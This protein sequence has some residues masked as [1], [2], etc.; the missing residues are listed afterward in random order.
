MD[1]TCPAEL[2]PPLGGAVSQHGWLKT[3]R[4]TH[5]HKLSS[6][7]HNFLI[8]LFCTLL[9]VFLT[10]M[11]EP[12]PALLREMTSSHVCVITRQYWE[13][14]IQISWMIWLNVWSLYSNRNIIKDSSPVFLLFPTEITEI[15]LLIIY[16]PSFVCLPPSF[17][18]PP[19]PFSPAYWT[20]KDSHSQ[21]L[22]YNYILGL[23]IQVWVIYQPNPIR[24][25][26]ESPEDFNDTQRQTEIAQTEKTN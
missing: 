8:L 21:R 2:N 10:A 13:S 9:S 7:T 3:T 11:L 23:L 25:K 6:G 19:S 24:Y 12:Q 15:T 16:S 14:P 22:L 17:A 1:S 5:P 20:N 26:E 4:S 18:L